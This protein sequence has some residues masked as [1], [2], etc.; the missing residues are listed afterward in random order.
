MPRLAETLG[1]TV[2]ALMAARTGGS[3]FGYLPP[4]RG[5]AFGMPQTNVK[6]M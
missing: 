6:S 4:C 3:L 1:A 5:A 2:D